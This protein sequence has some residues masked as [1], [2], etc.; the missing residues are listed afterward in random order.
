MYRLW[1]PGSTAADTQRTHYEQQGYRI[2]HICGYTVQNRPQYVGIWQMP[3]LSQAPYEI[4]YGISLDECLAKD[5]QLTQ[6][7]YIAVKFQAFNSGNR[8]L[9]TAIWEQRPGCSHRIECDQD[10]AVMHK[11]IL[12]DATM[13]PRQIS[14][15]IDPTDNCA[16]YV[17][18]W[19]NIDTFRYPTPPDLWPLNAPIPNR[20][21]KGSTEAF[22]PTKLRFLEKRIERFMRLGN[23]PG[24]SI[25]IAK[26]EC[27]KFAAGY[28][29]A[30]VRMKECVDPSH[31]FRIGS[32]SKPVTAAA[33]FLLVD[34]RKIRLDQKIFGPNSILGEQYG[35]KKPYQKYVCDITLRNLLEHT[36]GGW[37]NYKNDPF[38]MDAVFAQPLL[39][40]DKLIGY[41]MD[42]FPLDE[43]PGKDWLYSNFGYLV[44][45]KIIEYI[46]GKPY[47]QFVKEC[48]WTPSGVPDARIGGQ[49]ISE[50]L[51]KEVMYYMSGSSEGIDPY[52]LL[53]MQRIAP[54]GGWVASPIDMLK[55]MV[56]VDGFKNKPD[57]LSEASTTSWST[58]SLP[59]NDTYGMG[60]SLNLMGFN[61]WMHEG[62]MPGAVAMLIRLDSGV[63][64]AVALN[65]EQGDRDF[66]NQL[67]FVI[68]HIVSLCQTWPQAGDL[69]CVQ[70]SCT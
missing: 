44:L 18:L 14:H 70:G 41:V 3:T 52:E 4:Q 27:L 5:K 28:G 56:K 64:I 38:F 13:K 42:H 22:D 66:F 45:G 53:P 10:I 47:E 31:K 55:F 67:G 15:Y 24:L 60:W 37:Q 43:A 58:P 61:G 17:V 51:Q 49:Y 7:G 26:D 34:Q 68:H 69:F 59:S 63:E 62:R 20:Y 65:Q 40:N 8:V 48:I 36:S 50:K 9:C 35:S 19:S 39:D 6:Q 25:A 32:I 30:N 16:K 2:T 1:F 33:I 46:S 12:P 23:I 57:L 21:L 11:R 54:W 29:Y